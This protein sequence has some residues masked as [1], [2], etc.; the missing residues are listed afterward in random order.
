MVGFIRM[1]ISCD[2]RCDKCGLEQTINHVL[3]EC[4]PGLQGRY[5][6]YRQLQ[7][8]FH[9]LQ[10]YPSTVGFFL[11]KITSKLIH[12]QSDFSFIDIDCNRITGSSLLNRID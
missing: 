7:E 12:K 3:F 9:G 10:S 2:T 11:P 5:H 6:I 8:F 4:T 1:G